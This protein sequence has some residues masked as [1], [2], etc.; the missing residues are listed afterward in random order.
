[1]SLDVMTSADQCVSCPPGTTCSV[2]S[3]SPADC[4]L[5]TF[6]DE[7]GMQSCETCP[8][9][10]Y[11]PPGVRTR[12][13]ECPDGHWCN[14]GSKYPCGKSLY[15]NA[16]APPSSRTDLIACLPCPNGATTN[17]EATGSIKGCLCKPGYLTSPSLPI[18]DSSMCEACPPHSTCAKINTT[19]DTI[20]V[21]DR[22][23]RPGYLT[24]APQRCPRP[25]LCVNGTMP[26]AKYNRFS[27]AT[28]A[29][30]RGVAGVYCQL[31]LDESHYFSHDLSCRACD[32]GLSA[33][34]VL[35]PLAIVAIVIGLFWRY[36]YTRRLKKATQL[37]KRVALRMKLKISVGFYQIVTQLSAVYDITYYPPEYEKLM[38][39]FELANL[40]VFS[41]IPGLHP[42]C[43]GI[44]S[45]V[46]Q[47]YTFTIVP[48]LVAAASLIFVKLRGLQL[49]SALPF[50]L[51][52]SFLVFPSVSSRGFRALAPCNCFDVIGEDGNVTQTCFLHTDYAVRCTQSFAGR[53]MPELSVIVAA[54]LAIT[55]YGI[56]VPLFYALLLWC[57]KEWQLGSAID[58]LSSGYRPNAFWWELVEVG[59]KLI[60]TG[61]LALVEPGSLIQIFLA[62]AAAQVALVLQM[63]VSPY[64]N[65]TDHVIAL[66]SDVALA[67]T[68]LVTLGLEE[69]Q[70]SESPLAES[71][72]IVAILF[73][74]ALVVIVTF[75]GQLALDL[76]GLQLLCSN[77]GDVELTTLDGDHFHLF[78]SHVWGTGQDAM[79]IIKHR[80]I[81][82]LPDAHV[83]L[84][85]DIANFKTVDLEGYIQRSS[86]VLVHCTRGY[87]DS[88]NCMRELNTAVRE[89]KAIV[90]LIDPEIAHGGLSRA[91]IEEHI[92]NAASSYGKWG[93]ATDALRGDALIGA[94][95]FKSP[96]ELNRIGVHQLVTIRLIAESILPDVHASQTYVSGELSLQQPV[97]PPMQP[98]R[99]HV[100]CSP[101]NAGALELLREVEAALRITIDVTT[102]A[103]EMES[104]DKMVVYLNGQTWN[105]G[106]RSDALAADVQRAMDANV[107]LL[108]AHEMPS[109]VEIV[110]ARHS[111]EFGTFFGTTPDELIRKGIYHDVAVPLKGGE[112]RRTSLVMVAQGLGG[113]V[114]RPG[115]V[116]G[117]LSSLPMGEVVRS[118]R[119]W[120]F[121]RPP[122]LGEQDE[123][124]GVLEL[125]AQ[126][127]QGVSRKV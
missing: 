21:D 71:N 94:L 107:P 37:A 59:K 86:V 105:S 17:G 122:I 116:H 62:V 58:F 78:L 84:D 22:F 63:R 23:W 110:A 115:C 8:T 44:P 64:L 60:L 41:W 108:L 66:I 85:V 77:A 49:T 76:A 96:V 95:F 18:G 80:V 61:F 36:R 20:L 1:M 114:V 93:F 2:G 109:A 39:Y 35:L 25:E 126:S 51:G 9:A 43:L 113:Q 117:Y 12:C 13:D 98:G 75:G 55:L 52:W 65:Q 91:E 125:V 34:S 38:R 101:H 73:V 45:L 124:G 79:R 15:T 120:C 50:I 83:F 81:E 104:C 11:Q 87:F 54:W 106:E 56:G 67:F 5:G 27:N 46:S 14:S 72:A 97:P 103:N 68:M 42:T 90:A 92:H 31:C 4:P 10:T 28:C 70:Y 118:V 6:N 69:S 100:Y 48:L 111:I 26:D 47:L 123:Y 40:H 82:L 127:E 33:L 89:G 30:D 53:P 32:A 3:V 16:S 112:W 102:D 119:S 99:H 19:I 29:S 74:A 121:P 88:K 7:W 24:I 57:R